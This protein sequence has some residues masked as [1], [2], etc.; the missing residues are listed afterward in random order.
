M[1]D[2]YF[3]GVNRTICQILEEMRSL[4]RSRN[5]S[6]LEGLIEEAQSMAN[7]MESKL[8]TIKDIDRAEEAMKRLKKEIKELENKKEEIENKR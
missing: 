8:Y 7:R 2:Y 5:F 3:G 6:G 1:R 4:Y